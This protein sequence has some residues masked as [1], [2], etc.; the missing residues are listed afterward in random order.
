MR[1]NIKVTLYLVYYFF[2]IEN[3]MKSIIFTNIDDL[4][5]NF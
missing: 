5:F 2:F 3:L 4:L 1:A